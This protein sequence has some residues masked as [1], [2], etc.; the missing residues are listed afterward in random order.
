MRNIII[1]ILIAAMGGFLHTSA[2]AADSVRRHDSI[3]AISDRAADSTTASSMNIESTDSIAPASSHNESLFPNASRSL[4]TS[5]FTWGA[6]VGASIDLTGHDMSTFDADA[7]IGYKNRF[8]RTAGIGVG[9]HRSFGNGNQFIPIYAVFRSSFRSV[10]SLFFFTLKAG[11]SFNTIGDSPVFGDVAGS[12]GA[13]VN[14][15]MSRKFQ[16]HI[17]LSF[18]FR[19]FNERHRADT[20][21]DTDDVFM[22]QIGFGVNF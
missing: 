22:A 2:R 12:I 15:A 20:S 7:I 16:S 17:T 19:H 18:G 10:P 1:T 4:A 9:I 21:L 14:L 8:I 3:Y 6:E 5:H 11:Y 13:G